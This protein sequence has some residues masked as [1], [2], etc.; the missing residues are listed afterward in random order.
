MKEETYYCD[1]CSSQIREPLDSVEEDE[2]GNPTM[3]VEGP[4]GTD[5]DETTSTD[6]CGKC[7][8]EF[9]KWLKNTS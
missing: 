1:R 5:V 4:R 9:Q 3:I 2:I 7:N 8:A 6:L